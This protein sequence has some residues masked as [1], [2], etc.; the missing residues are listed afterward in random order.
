MN[1]DYTQCW[2][3]ETGF[4]QLKEDDGEKNRSRNWH[5]Q[6]RELTCWCI[7]HDLPQAAS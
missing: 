2:M 6:Y 1:D 7:I 3:S 5:G 4:S